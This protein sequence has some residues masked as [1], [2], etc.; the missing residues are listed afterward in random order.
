[1][2]RLTAAAHCQRCD[3]TAGPG[4]PATTDKQADKHTRTTSHPTATIATPAHFTRETTPRR[5][6]N[7]DHEQQHPRASSGR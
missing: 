2:T 1:M 6:E 3:W 4:D 5:Q 7:S